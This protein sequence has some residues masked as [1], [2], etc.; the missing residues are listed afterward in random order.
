ML[1]IAGLHL[2]ALRAR[3]AGEGNKPPH[4]PHSALRGR[5]ACLSPAVRL[6]PQLLTSCSTLP[7]PS[8]FPIFHLYYLM[9]TLTGAA[10]RSW[11]FRGVGR[12]CCCIHHLPKWK[13]LHPHCP[14]RHHRPQLCCTDQHV[15]SGGL[16]A[17]FSSG[18]GLAILYERIRS[19]RMRT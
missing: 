19:P 1:V 16:V 5:V 8:S 17:Y 10:F 3:S 15:F 4:E 7:L 13:T 12:R 2:L 6:H 9:L 18:A 11:V 14:L